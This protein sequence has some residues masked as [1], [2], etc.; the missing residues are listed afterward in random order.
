MLSY[1]DMN[2]IARFTEFLESFSEE[3]LDEIDQLYAEKIDF[4]DPINQTKE[5]EHFKRIEADLFKQLKEIKFEIV[6][7]KGDDHEAM[8]KWVMRYRFRFWKRE[9][10]GMS[11]LKFNEQNQIYFQ[12]DFWD[13]S[14]AIYGEFPLIGLAMKG[15]RKILRVS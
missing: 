5:R 8:V 11:H 7:S 1:L 12:H 14:F 15:I 3:K 2:N 10:E 13:A 4:K 6:A 9:I